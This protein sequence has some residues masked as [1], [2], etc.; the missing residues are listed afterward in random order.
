MVSHRGVPTRP[1]W[2]SYL[3][4]NGDEL[5]SGFLAGFAMGM[6]DSD[7]ESIEAEEMGNGDGVVHITAANSTPMS[8][9]YMAMHILLLTKKNTTYMVMVFCST[10]AEAEETLEFLKQN[11]SFE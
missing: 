5:E 3:E 7:I 4:E 10:D 2:R 1:R 9:D 8:A 11:I 6:G